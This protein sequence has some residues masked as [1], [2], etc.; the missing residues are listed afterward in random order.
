MPVRIPA[1]AGWKAYSTG[2]TW[3]QPGFDFR[4]V[5]ADGF[6]A[7]MPHLRLRAFQECGHSGRRDFVPQVGRN[8]AGERVAGG[9]VELGAVHPASD[10]GTVERTQFERRIHVS[11]TA[12]DGIVGSAAITDDNLAPFD[13]DEFHSAGRDL[14]G[15]DSAN[16][17]VSQGPHPLATVGGGYPDR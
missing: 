13:L 14:G 12:R 6:R 17:L 11:A 1:N 2:A 4:L 3:T 10:I 15:G 8:G 7:D 5:S 16:E 9:D